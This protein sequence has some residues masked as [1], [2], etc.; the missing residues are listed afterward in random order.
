MPH[1]LLSNS[2]MYPIRIP[3]VRDAYIIENAFLE[4]ILFNR[5]LVALDFTHAC[6]AAS[7][8][9]MRHLKPEIDA[10][11]HDVAELLLL[12]K[13]IYYR[14]HNAFDR[15]FKRN[16]ELN[17]VAT[18]RVSVSD[19]EMKIAVPYVDIS[20]PA[21]TLLVGDTVAS[22]ATLTAALSYYLDHASLR[23]LIVFSIVGSVTGAQAIAQFCD[24]NNI[25]FSIA[26]GLA[27]FGLARNGFDLSFLHP[28]TITD[29]KYLERAKDVFQNK[30]ISSAGWDFGSQAQ[31]TRKYKMLCWI[32]SQYWGLRIGEVFRLTDERVDK[33]L[34]AKESSAFKHMLPRYAGNDQNDTEE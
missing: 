16:L 3:G 20:A 29:A 23:R 28:D 25:E 7:A 33:A 15:T 9:F 24:Q 1:L 13:G 17:L 32:E 30:P 8:L 26:F 19:Q 10:N 34:V 12:T 18:K 2:R 31:S 14:F 4:S 22:G 21:T 11:G 5:N 6:E 27:A